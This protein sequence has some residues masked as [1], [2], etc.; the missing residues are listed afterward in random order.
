MNIH[1]D[2]IKLGRD[3]FSAPIVQEEEQEQEKKTY[4]IRTVQMIQSF[5]NNQRS[6]EL[7]ETD[8]VYQNFQIIKF[9]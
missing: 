3:R 5:I 6:E 7:Q 9:I 4:F 1:Q 2:L 8:F